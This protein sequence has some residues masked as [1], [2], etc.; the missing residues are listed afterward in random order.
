MKKPVYSI[1]LH[2]TVDLTPC[3]ACGV[4][5]PESKGLSLM[6]DNAPMCATCGKTQ[7]PVLASLLAIGE[8]AIFDLAPSYERT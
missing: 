4:K 1:Q 8:L 5:L 7:E 3:C 2:A 6:R